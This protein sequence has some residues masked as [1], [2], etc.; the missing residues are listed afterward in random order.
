M[1]SSFVSR[2]L[3]TSGSK[4]YNFI[5]IDLSLSFV[6]LEFIILLAESISFLAS[7]ELDQS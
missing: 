7:D 4:S 1:E 2:L 3:S 5:T 6:G